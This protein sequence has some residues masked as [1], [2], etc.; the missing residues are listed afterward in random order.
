M[1]ELSSF[2]FLSSSSFF[3]HLSHLFG[4][5]IYSNFLFCLLYSTSTLAIANIQLEV[6]QKEVRSVTVFMVQQQ[7]DQLASVDSQEYH[8]AL[9]NNSPVAQAVCTLDGTIV[10]ANSAYAAL[11]NITL[12]DVLGQNFWGFTPAKYRSH[13]QTCDNSL[14]QTGKFTSEQ[15]YLNRD[16][17]S[18]LV[19]LSGVK[20]ELSEKLFILLTVERIAKRQNSD[21][22]S[23]LSLAP[24]QLILDEIPPFIFWK[25]LNSTYLGCNQ[26]FAQVAGLTSPAE[27]IGKTDYDLAG[28]QSESDWLRECDR[29]VM[30][31]G[32]PEYNIIES[33]KQADGTEKW[34]K[35]NKIPLHDDRGKVIGIV[36]TFEDITERVELERQL[37]E[38]NISLETLVTKR[39][40]E[41]TN[42][43]A[44]FERLALN[45]P[46]A[47]YQFKLDLD[48]QF[49][50]PYISSGCHELYE[51]TP[52]QIMAEPDLILSSIHPEDREDFQKVV[53]I[54][55]QTLQSKRWEGRVVLASGKIKWVKT[56]SRPEK[57][58]DGTV[59]W[60]GLMMDMSDHQQAE[61][62]LRE[63][64]Q[65]LQFIFDTLPQ[66]IFWKD[67]NFN[68]LGCNRLFAQDAGLQFP[69]EIIGKNDFELAWHK[70]AHLY[71]AD[72]EIII[73]GGS[74]KLNYEESQVREDGTLIK[75][76]TSKLPLR[77]ENGQ[78]IGLFGCY[79]D[80][81]VFDNQKRQVEI[82]KDFLDKV[83]NSIADPIF[84]KNADHQWIILNDAFCRFIGHTKEELLGKSDY[85]FF[86]KEE[87][88][89][90]WAKDELVM[91][92]EEPDI[93][94]EFLT[95]A[96]NNQKVILT[97]KTCFHD[98]E[99]NTFLVGIITDLTSYRQR[100]LSGLPKTD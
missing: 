40:Q 63:S 26:K 23:S 59:V 76:R 27:I 46:G 69:E 19:R 65:L 11:L 92:T 72:D 45:I 30:E 90:F 82:A 42:S 16:N 100:V 54:S 79:E 24:L 44:R 67:K 10:D 32:I 33:Q 95:D 83:V 81:S 57:Q 41:L 70:S 31:S 88:D 39:T 3:D 71:R 55:A 36:G 50:F 94:E 48:G 80:I 14:Q 6:F 15:E 97:K 1:K 53:A 61:Q 52:E 66:R 86:S 87:A 78:I 37:K 28:K 58:A 20:I 21:I 47:I 4:K 73:A 7:S 38:Q 77:D 18:I 12:V 60:D 64:Q 43:Q 9:W 68:Y 62:E 22:V 51:L 5:T 93:N 91:I 96:N 56:A 85:D 35:T 89:I 13:K 34:L 17:Q 2:N 84:V 25:D 29:R 49:S 75:C 74:A 8:Q 99:G 98:F